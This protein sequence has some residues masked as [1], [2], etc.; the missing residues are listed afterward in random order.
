MQTGEDGF[1][2]AVLSG[3]HWLTVTAVQ[4]RWRVEDQWWRQPV[5]RYYYEVWLEGGTVETL[6]QDRVGSAWF[7]QRD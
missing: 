7:L 3:R 2:Q 6:F 5:S 4:D 1:P